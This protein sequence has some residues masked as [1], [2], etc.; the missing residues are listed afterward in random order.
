MIDRGMTPALVQSYFTRP[1]RLVNPARIQEIKKE[2]VGAAIVPASDAELDAFL[3]DFAR[4][5]PQSGL[6]APPKQ[7]KNASTFKTEN[8]RIGLISER[9]TNYVENVNDI[10][11]L[12]QELRAKLI[13]L[14]SVGHNSLGQV[15]ADVE[16]FLAAFPEN[17]EDASIIKIWMRGN[18][19]RARL[20]SYEAYKANSDLYPLIEI[21]AAVVPIFAD[22]VQ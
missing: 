10:I 16:T 4:D 14:T 19:L 11:D 20:K 12:Y 15:Q 8:G 1:G 17:H 13:A 3:D 2:T 6:Y 7:E 18:N 22:L 21:D 9:P 5:H